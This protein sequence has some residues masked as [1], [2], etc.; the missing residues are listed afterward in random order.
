MKNH[1]AAKRMLGALCL[2]LFLTAAPAWT[3][4]GAQA[5]EEAGE[6]APDGA[7][8]DTEL[9]KLLPG[10]WT[11]KTEEGETVLTLDENG[12]MALSFS[13]MA[14]G[15]GCSYSG[16]WSL[17]SVPDAG[18][19]MTLLFTSTDN[20]VR[21]GEAYSVTCVYEAYTESWV[22]NDTLVT[23]LNLN[24]PVSCSGV[25]PFE[26]VSGFD[27]AALFREQGPNRQV[28]K[29]KSFVS[30]REKRAASSR[31]LAK[32]PLGALVLAFP[33]EGEE[34]GFT[35]CVY[36]GKRGYILSEYLQTAE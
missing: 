3:R 17:E 19:R 6:A 11:E 14:G 36:Q 8:R 5:R 4:P 26:E 20:P 22:E 32:V 16:T 23:C 15:A 18:S 31:R 28:V 34:N 27:G 9:L 1:P 33:E 7:F 25:S 13:G 30:L 12:T 35:A 24:P 29:C 21:A 10:Q 2:L